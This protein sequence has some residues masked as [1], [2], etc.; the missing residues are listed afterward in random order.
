MTPEDQREAKI[1]CHHTEEPG[2]L[3]GVPSDIH[4]EIRHTGGE[5]IW[6]AGSLKHQSNA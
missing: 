5:A 3:I 6:G 2:V 4:R 1:T